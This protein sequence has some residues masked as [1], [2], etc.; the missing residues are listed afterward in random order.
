MALLW[1][2]NLADGQ[3]SLLRMAERA[4]LPFAT[5]RAAADRLV[6]AELLEPMPVQDSSD[7]SCN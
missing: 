4:E 2:L 5:I 3:H 6:A 1:V 7:V